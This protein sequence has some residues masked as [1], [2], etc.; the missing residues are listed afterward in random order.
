MTTATPSAAD[1]VYAQVKR[2]IL[3]GGLPGGSLVTEGGL[4][5]ASGV[6]RRP[7]REALLRLEGEG[8]VRL[9]PRRAPSSSRRRS[10]TLGTSSRPASS[11]RSG[12]RLRGVAAPGPALP[13][14][15]A[16]LKSMRDAGFGGGRPAVE[17]DRRLHEIVVQAAG[18]AV[19]ARTYLGLRDRQLTILAAQ[20]RRD[21]D[22]IERAVANH[23]RLLEILRTGTVEELVAE[24]HTHVHTAL[25]ALQ[26]NR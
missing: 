25:A 10:T 23:E 2:D 19:L 13:A 5:E 11:S 17:R 14:L 6:S 1:R 15:D 22:R 26:V 20:F 3:A 12:G 4:A 18:N 8:L 21:G 7:V 24:T 16:E 9:Y